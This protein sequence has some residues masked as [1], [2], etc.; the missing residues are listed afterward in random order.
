MGYFNDNCVFGDGSCVLDFV[1]V[2]EEVVLDAI[3]GPEPIRFF[4]QLES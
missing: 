4:L 2:E 1:V 3:E